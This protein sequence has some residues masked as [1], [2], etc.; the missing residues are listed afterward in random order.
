MASGNVTE[1]FLLNSVPGFT[2]PAVLPRHTFYAVV[3]G[4]HRL[5][6]LSGRCFRCIARFHEFHRT[7]PFSI[8]YSPTVASERLLRAGQFGSA[9]GSFANPI[10]NNA[11]E[12]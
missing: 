9:W 11:A 7:L 10:A 8:R 1:T 3:N 2:D 4:W 5:A 6:K 12:G